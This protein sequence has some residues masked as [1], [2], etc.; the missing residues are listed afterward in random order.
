MSRA[1]LEL[2][3]VLWGMIAFG[4]IVMRELDPRISML[5]KKMDCR[6]SRRNRID[7]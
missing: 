2:Q 1:P 5:R 6:S 3:G 7:P 4:E